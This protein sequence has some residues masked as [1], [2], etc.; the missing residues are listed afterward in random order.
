MICEMFN[1]EQRRMA[2][3]LTPE[4]ARIAYE[5]SG[6]E[7]FFAGGEVAGWRRPESAEEL[8]EYVERHRIARE[9]R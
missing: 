9:R 7:F 4:T 1:A 8:Q 5:K 2:N 6:Y 3:K